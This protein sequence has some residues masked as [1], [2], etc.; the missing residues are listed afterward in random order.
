MI[1]KKVFKLIFTVYD[2]ATH[3]SKQIAQS[4]RKA[5]YQSRGPLGPS[6]AHTRD[7]PLA[8][9]NERLREI[10]IQTRALIGMLFS[11]TNRA[12]EVYRLNMVR[13]NHR[14]WIVALT[15]DGEVAE[16]RY[17]RRTIQ[18]TSMFDYFKRTV[19]V[20]QGEG[21]PVLRIGQT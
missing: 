3:T 12:G 7:C 6:H 18:G 9:E 4:R 17:C 14:T 2:M 8:V 16:K 1:I 11:R 20:L 10:E 15:A 21:Y 5:Y 19:N 13:R